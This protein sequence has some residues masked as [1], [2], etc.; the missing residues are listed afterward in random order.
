MNSHHGHLV[1]R[2]A[3]AA[4][5]AAASGECLNILDAWVGQA[6]VCVCVCVC[7]LV[8]VCWCVG[9]CGSRGRIDG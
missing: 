8:C 6:R 9:V 3:A 5:A 4:A 7:V 1:D 2:D